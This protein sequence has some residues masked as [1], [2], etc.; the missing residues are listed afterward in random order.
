MQIHQVIPKNI[1]YIYN[2]TDV[3]RIIKL[4]FFYACICA[5]LTV[6]YVII[7]RHKKH[8]FSVF[9]FQDN[10]LPVKEMGYFCSDSKWRIT[11]FFVHYK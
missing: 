3:K 2:K 4:E 5:S 7:R 6:Y 9:K 1:K 11:G 10:F 8:I